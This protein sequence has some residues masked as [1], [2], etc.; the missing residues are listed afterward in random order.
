M[1]I[2]AGFAA[3]DRPALAAI[4]WDA[5]G[6]KLGRAL[7]PRRRA[8]AFLVRALD[9]AHA[10]VARGAGGQVLGVA[11][12]RDGAGGLVA[13]RPGDFLAAYGVAAPLRALA[14]VAIPR[15][16]D[17]A[18]FLVDGL[19]VAAGARGQGVG[20]RLLAALAGLAAGRGHREIRLDVAEGN[21]RARALYERE[22]FVAA[23]TRRPGLAG[24]LLGLPPTVTMVRR[25]A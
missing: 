11:G 23:G 12:I 15:D 21:L 17:N 7:G 5:F 1:R 25:L 19:A 14:L 22:G 2:E 13:G 16:V 3:S 6:D 4:Y 18:R 8:E 24:P 9:P 20:T 10:L